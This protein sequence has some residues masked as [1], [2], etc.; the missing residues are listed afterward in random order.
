MYQQQWN[1]KGG[2]AKREEQ[3]SVLL[4]ARGGILSWLHQL[5]SS[6]VPLSCPLPCSPDG[7]GAFGQQSHVLIWMVRN[8][9]I[10]MER[11]RSAPGSAQLAL[12]AVTDC[13]SDL[14]LQQ[15]LTYLQCTGP[16]RGLG[17][18]TLWSLVT[19]LGG[20]LRICV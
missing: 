19:T 16:E 8:C 11:P 20:T 7:I 2:T 13:S 10:E 4:Q 9:W 14:I 5:C 1:K 18:Y 12:F 3:Q 15:P 17:S 6:L